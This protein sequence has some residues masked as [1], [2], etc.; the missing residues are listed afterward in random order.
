[1]NIL[2]LIEYLNK[3]KRVKIIDLHGASIAIIDFDKA[4][5]RTSL[6]IDLFKEDERIS[7]LSL[8][9]A[10]RYKVNDDLETVMVSVEI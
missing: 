5:Q 2:V 1:M 9:R 6:Y 10:K 7:C 8:M 3:Y 4:R